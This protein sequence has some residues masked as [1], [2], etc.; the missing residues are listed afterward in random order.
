MAQVYTLGRVGGVQAHCS[1]K[2]TRSSIS[3]RLKGRYIAALSGTGN[4]SMDL[5]EVKRTKL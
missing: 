4:G 1:Y 3:D 2:A 5:Y